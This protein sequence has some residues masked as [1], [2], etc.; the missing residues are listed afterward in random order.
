MDHIWLKHYPPGVSPAVNLQA[1]AS[2]KDVLRS[3]FDRF[4]DLPA[5][6]SL[7]AMLTYAELDAAS[8]D[9]A[10]YLQH[11]LALNKGDRVAL[12][13]PNL[14]QY[15]VALFGV[16]RAGLV[17]VNIDPHCS[18]PELAHRLTDSGAR[19][20]VVLENFAHTLQDVLNAHPLAALTVITTEVGDLL[21]VMQEVLT[22]VVV[23]YVKKLVPPWKIEGATGFNAAMRAGR[24]QPLQHVVLT[25]R[26][27][28]LLQ[29]AQAATGEARGVM[30]THGNLV[31]N[32]LQL[33]SWLAQGLADGRE[34][35]VCAL[36]WHRPPALVGSLVFMTV[37]AHA[38]LVSQPNDTAALIHDLR[39]YRFTALLG[40]PVQYAALLDA[41]GFS[42]VAVNR[43]TCACAAGMAVPRL[44]AERWKAATGVPLVE[45]Y[46]LSE[47]SA[48]VTCNDPAGADWSGT[49]GMPLPLTEVAIWGDDGR[50]LGVGL[51]GEV[52][53]RG[54]QVMAGYW[55]R[56]RDTE[57]ALAPGNWLR[58]GDMGLMDERG[59]T[60][61]MGRRQDMMRVAGFKVFPTQIED[62]VALHP[63]VQEVA[64]MGCPAGRSGEAVK[65][66]V[67]RKD[68]ALT[69]AALLAYCRQHLTDY[70]VP[71]WIEFSKTPL[72]KTVTGKMVRQGLR[73]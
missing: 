52:V 63:G 20:V 68:P 36:P 35:L 57:S 51:V 41:P 61:I 50:E 70:K 9:F 65:I 44:L 21:P 54:P 62:V 6:T 8:R 58:T 30:L 19:V 71:Q 53:V 28:A 56:P 23:K 31:A 55:Q 48:V 38:V 18:A 29:Y 4:S 13:M 32:V 2:V 69:E 43:L 45:A 7:G 15:P 34:L 14:L 27:L 49:A 72:P 67:Y 17:V 16:L 73:G 60:K 24:E 59:H 3:C 5:Y 37:G 22:N 66:V 26:D 11:R 42:A 1:F 10:A 40:A 33:A 46:G 12:M 39:K 25:G 47:A 64:A